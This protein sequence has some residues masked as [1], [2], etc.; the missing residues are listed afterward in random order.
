MTKIRDC[1]FLFAFYLAACGAE[2]WVE[3]LL[4]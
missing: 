4:R 2:G 3:L 1:L